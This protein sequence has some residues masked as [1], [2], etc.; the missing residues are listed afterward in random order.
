MFV[1]VP[2]PDSVDEVE[3]DVQGVGVALV[4]VCFKKNLSR[5]KSLLF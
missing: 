4:Q 2:D 1:K 3:F 5:G